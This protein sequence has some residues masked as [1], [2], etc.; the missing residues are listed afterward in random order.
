MNKSYLVINKSCGECYPML[1]CFTRHEAEEM[2][3]SFCQEE[4]YRRYYID[5]QFA[6]PKGLKSIYTVDNSL[7]NMSY[8]VLEV[9]SL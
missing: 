4:Q 8:D 3:L 9:P 6:K 7:K 2:C 5:E 1:I